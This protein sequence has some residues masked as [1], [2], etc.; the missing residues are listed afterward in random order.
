MRKMWTFLLLIVCAGMIL[1]QPDGTAEFNHR[2]LSMGGC[3]AAIAGEGSY[4]DIF[5]ISDGDNPAAAHFNEAYTLIPER[6]DKIGGADRFAF[7][8]GF[9]S[10]EYPGPPADNGDKR[11][12]YWIDGIGRILVEKGFSD[13]FSTRFQFRGGYDTMRKN[14]WGEYRHNYTAGLPDWSDIRYR[15]ST[16]GAASILPIG[17]MYLNYHSPFGLSVG[18]GGGYGFS[19]FED[20]YYYH[21]GWH[22][23][24]KGRVSSYRVKFGARFA[25]P[26]FEQFGAVGLNYGIKGGTATD[27]EGEDYD[28]YTN[29]DNT[30]GFQAQ[31]GMPGFFRAALGYDI[32]NLSEDYFVSAEDEEADVAEDEISRVA[33]GIQAY[34]NGFNVPI[35]VGI[36]TESHSA[37]GQVF[38]SDTVID[39]TKLTRSDTRI[40]LS[41]EPINGWTITA[42]YKMGADKLEQ[43]STL[44]TEDS[45]AQVDWSA[46]AG[47]MEI[48]V[49]E[50]FGIRF[51]FENFSY[52]PD[53]A[54]VAAIGEFDYS[55]GEGEFVLPIYMPTNRYGAVPV[56]TKG[57]AITW[58]LV[59]RLD[60]KRLFLELSGRHVLADE[61]QVYDDIP[62]NGHE[63]S[64]GLTYYL[65]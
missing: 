60:D 4:L 12:W 56:Q 10:L 6:I 38:D 9:R 3:E 31:A 19:E 32:S 20:I 39:E 59:F 65:K 40:G 14:Y 47:G 41:S 29:S 17:E 26:G 45:D 1:A 52:E 36:K 37:E 62:G 30:V 61:P 24:A 28:M 64:L 34:G 58:G 22:T 51:G 11:S 25:M 5:D 18:A 53:S 57:N 16:T 8:V 48:Y 49:V 2:G 23:T 33:F 44:L 54:Y 55:G 50:E 35:T 63:A 7:D 21:S 46:I 43:I 15:S 13:N 27:E 42:E